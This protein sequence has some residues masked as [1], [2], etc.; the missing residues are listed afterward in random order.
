[1]RVSVS[2]VTSFI[3][4]GFDYGLFRTR[5]YDQRPNIS[6]GYGACTIGAQGNV[7]ALAAESLRIRATLATLSVLPRERSLVAWATHQPIE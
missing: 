2:A 1:M 5:D 4:S 7:L 6:G 3:G